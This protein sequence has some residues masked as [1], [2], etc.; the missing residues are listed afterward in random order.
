MVKI[1]SNLGEEVRTRLINFLQKN[2]DIFAWVLTDM[3]GIDAE[4]IEH[5]LAVDP[6]HRSIKKKI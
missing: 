6:K 2:V 3:L 4:V 5:R 1:G